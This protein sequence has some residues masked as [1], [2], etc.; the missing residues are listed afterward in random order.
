MTTFQHGAN[1]LNMEDTSHRER[2]LNEGKTSNTDKQKTIWKVDILNANLISDEHTTFSELIFHQHYFV[3]WLHTF[4]QMYADEMCY[5]LDFN[6]E[7]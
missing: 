2:P 7:E 5:G 3:K 6:M 1:T 4:P